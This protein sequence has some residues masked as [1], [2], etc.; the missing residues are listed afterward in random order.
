MAYG[1]DEK[2][3]RTQWGERS[4][5]IQRLGVIF[6]PIMRRL[7]IT[8]T[9]TDST[10]SSHFSLKTLKIWSIKFIQAR[11]IFDNNL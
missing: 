9:T 5:G 1:D 2:D 6:L 8:F 11:Y 3:L 4:G 7:L 10:I